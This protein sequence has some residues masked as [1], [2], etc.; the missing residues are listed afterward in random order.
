MTNS[1]GPPK[2]NALH[3]SLL[4]SRDQLLFIARSVSDT[5]VYEWQLFQISY[6][7]TM[8]FHTN[9]F[10]DG[11]NLVYLYIMHPEDKD[12]FAINQQYWLEYH[13]KKDLHQSDHALSYHI[14]KPT[15]DSI[16]YAKSK[17]LYPYRQLVYMTHDDVFIHGPFD[18]LC[19]PTGRQ[20]RDSIPLDPWISL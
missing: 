15:R 19:I 16:L 18:F 12:C 2:I 5:S 9:C 7:D 20:G 8:Q 3:A 10:Q 14:L 11:Q 1:N 17:G 4:H 6:E 13:R